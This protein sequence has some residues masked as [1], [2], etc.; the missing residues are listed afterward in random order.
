MMNITL[1]TQLLINGILLGGI[2]ALVSLGLVLIVGVLRIVNFAHGDFLMVAMYVT[3][4][5]FSLFHVPLT[6]SFV[7]VVI[8]FFFIGLFV[9]RLF[10]QPILHAQP[11]ARLMVTVGLSIIIQNLAL[12]F[13]KADFRSIQI[14][15]STASIQIA[16]LFINVGGLTAFLI[17][18][19]VGIILL[20][21]LKKTYLGLAIRAIVQ[22][23]DATKLMG[24]NVNKLYLL[25]FG[26][27][28]ACVGVAGVAITPLYPVFPTVGLYFVIISFI[29]LVIGGMG[30]FLGAFFGGLLIGLVESFSGFLLGP[31]LKEAVYLLIFIIVLLIAPTGL[32]GLGKGSEELG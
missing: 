16:G 25:S 32:F 11:F 1:I 17:A 14:S 19:G 5:L 9:Q 20:L 12:L 13:W 8:I 31:S 30:N 7:I 15:S 28:M 22:N 18:M 24:V 10:I 23:R 26:I 3:Y 27:G 29:I 6:I 21:F 2:Y 4:F